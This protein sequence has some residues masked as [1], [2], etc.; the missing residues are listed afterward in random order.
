MNMCRFPESDTDKLFETKRALALR[1]ILK[2]S[3]ADESD[4]KFAD[5]PYWFWCGCLVKRT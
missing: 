3:N 4:D 2:L 1:T 5:P